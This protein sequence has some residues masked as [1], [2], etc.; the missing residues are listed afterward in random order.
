MLLSGIC[1]TRAVDLPAP[2]PRHVYVELL[3]CIYIYMMSWLF[4]VSY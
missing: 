3:G 4:L 2:L 1:A